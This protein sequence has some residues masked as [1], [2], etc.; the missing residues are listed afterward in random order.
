MI[1]RANE[2][3]EIWSNYEQAD[4]FTFHRVDGPANCSDGFCK[5][6]RSVNYDS[7][8]ETTGKQKPNSKRTTATV[9]G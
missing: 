1:H 6:S 2:I 9:C 5:V 3:C 8:F 4:S 7:R